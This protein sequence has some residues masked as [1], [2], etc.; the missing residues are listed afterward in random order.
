MSIAHSNVD[1]GSVK[2]SE[3]H[4]TLIYKLG[5]YSS[6]LWTLQSKQ[7]C[8]VLATNCQPVN[9][10]SVGEA[11]QE[12]CMGHTLHMC[13]SLSLFHVSSFCYSIIPCNPSSQHLLQLTRLSLLSMNPHLLLYIYATMALNRALWTMLSSL[14]ATLAKWSVILMTT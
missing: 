11:G 6:S 1:V 12:R 4:P 10:R 2:L 5:K 7:I 3:Q 9:W 14:A 13:T 8:L